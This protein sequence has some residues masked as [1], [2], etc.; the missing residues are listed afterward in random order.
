VLQILAAKI[1]LVG[2]LIG[3]IAPSPGFSQAAKAGSDYSAEPFIYEFLH[4]TMRYESEGTGS[5]EVQGRIRVNTAAGLARAGQLVFNYNAANE[6]LDV[7][8]VQ[9]IKA[10]RSVI[11]AGPEAVQDLSS[12]LARLAPM[13]TDAR[14]KHVTV[15]GLE[16]GDTVDYDVATVTVQ[17]LMPGQFW[18]T[19]N[20][21][22]D[23][24]CLEEQVDLNVPLNRSIKLKSPPGIEPA[25]HQ[26]GDRRIYHW[27][28]SNLRHRDEADFFNNFKFDVPSLLQGVRLP[29]GRKIMFS[30]F[31][32]W[33]EVGR[34]YAQLERDRRTPTP[35]IRALAD[36]IVKG[37]ATELDKVHALY[38]WVSRNIRYVSLSF[39]VGRYQP[40]TAAEVLANRY[41]DCK[42]KTTLLEALLE[43]EGFHGQA[44]LIHSKMDL[45]AAVP[46]PHQ[47]DHAITLVR[48]AGEDKWLDSTLGVGPFG[49]LL[50]QLRGKDA[51]VVFT[52]AAPALSQDAV[53]PSHVHTLQHRA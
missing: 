25:V 15:P 40:H 37:Q 11:H 1:F 9:V 4:A 2:A 10:D 33:E 26:D 12:P 8:S 47:F 42:D 53:R 31:Q 28:A 51:L 16:V 39:G 38:D 14:Q 52:D 24:I 21:T 43:A 5:L 19:W 34:W 44:V 23:A 48:I 13:Y 35:E 41:G 17:P 49:Y 6:K 30:T 7:R 20:F 32:S 36:S 29:P 27:A 18:Q 22:D 3:S 45:D 46:T 50:P